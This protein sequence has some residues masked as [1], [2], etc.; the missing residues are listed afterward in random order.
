MRKIVAQGCERHV[1]DL[2]RRCLNTTACA[3][4]SDFSYEHQHVVYLEKV[5]TSKVFVRDA[6]LVSPYALLLFG[7]SAAPADRGSLV[8]GYV[9]GSHVPPLMPS[10]NLPLHLVFDTGGDIEADLEKSIIAVDEWIKFDAPGRIAA[11]ANKLRDGMQAVRWPT[12]LHRIWLFC[13]DATPQALNRSSHHWPFAIFLSCW[14]RRSENQTWTLP[15]TS[16][17]RL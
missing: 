12:L 2:L 17:S 5:Q 14:K 13:L 11:L 6:S 4:S 7:A 15:L 10:F 1:V 16:S 9:L 3:V 8:E